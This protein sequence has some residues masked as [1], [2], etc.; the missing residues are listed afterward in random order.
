[1]IFSLWFEV[2]DDLLTGL[3]PD[4]PKLSS[5]DLFNVG[6]TKVTKDTFGKNS[7]LQYLTI[8]NEKR[9]V[10]FDISLDFVRD[11]DVNIVL[12]S[13][14]ILTVSVSD[15]PSPGNGSSRVIFDL[16]S[17]RLRCDCDM[18][19]FIEALRQKNSR[20]IF[21]SDLDSDVPCETPQGETLMTIDLDKLKC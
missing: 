3:F 1:M 13:N 18:K 6:L 5:I 9:L 4:M 14:Q 21:S 20:I 19:L 15:V 8:P 10:S 7:Q 16:R 12:G 11:N 2:S 17:S